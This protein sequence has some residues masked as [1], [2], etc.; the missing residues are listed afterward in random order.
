MDNLFVYLFIALVL[1]ILTKIFII[2]V[3]IPIILIVVFVGLSI[4]LKEYIS[5]ISLLI[6]SFL[7]GIYITPK[8]IDL[9]KLPKGKPVYLECKVVS[10][11]QNYYGKS[12]FNCKVLSSELK[13][14]EG[15]QITVISNLKPD[16]L[17]NIYALGKIKTKYDKIYLKADIP[18]IKEEK[19]KFI[20]L[21]NS[22]RNYLIDLFKKQTLN[23]QSFAIGNAL[24]F[25]DR[26]YI[27]KETKNAYLQTGLIHLLAIS[28]FHI[29]IIFSV[30]FLLI[31]PISKKLA[32]ITT[33]LFL[34]VFVFISGFKIPVVRASIGGIFFAIGKIKGYKLNFLNLLFFIAFISILVE[35]YTIFSLSFQLSFLAVLGIFLVWQKLRFNI[36][37]KFLDFILKSYITSLVA[38]LFILPVL[39]FNFGKFSLIS[40][41]FTTPLIAIL[42]PYV[43]LEILNLITLFQIKFLV[44][45]MDYVGVIFSNLVKWLSKFEIMITNHYI[46]ILYLILY[47]LALIFIYLLPVKIIY[48]V[49]LNILLFIF[50][51]SI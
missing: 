14:L 13:D 10:F 36:K 46:S 41:L 18:F 19:S 4:F 5:L 30:I 12:K 3:S 1:G 51:I 39:L 32:Y 48:F 8:P 33:I 40:I 6:T 24:I 47:Y 50:I 34:S 43:F 44:N 35:P 9:K 21:V 45:V 7:L 42:Y 15:K 25:G 23:H 37:N 28:G 27:D 11:F 2:P 26:S 20:S 22:F 38:S 49:L 17:S 16:F 29:A 31:S